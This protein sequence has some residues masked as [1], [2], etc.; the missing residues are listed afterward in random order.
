[1]KIIYI[2]NM[3]LDKYREYVRNEGFDVGIAPLSDSFYLNSKYFNKFIEYTLSGMAGIY[4]N[5]EPYTFVVKDRENGYLAENNSES[6]YQVIKTAIDDK[7][8]RNK[9][10]MGAR[11]TLEE[12]FSEEKISQKYQ[13]EIPELTTFRSPVVKK[14][15]HLLTIKIRYF[16]FL[17]VDR[18]IL[19]A[20]YQKRLGTR[21]LLLKVTE[22]IR[23]IY[24]KRLL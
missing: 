3:P 14:M 2:D 19:L 20:K 7:D 1:M 5:C 9:C 13:E 21:G 10:I 6:W 22:K 16:L 8:L 4:S 11:I 15:P 17:T 12:D 18:C 23:L 24:N